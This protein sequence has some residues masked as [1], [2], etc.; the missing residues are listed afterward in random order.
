MDLDAR[1]IKQAVLR[2][3]FV[4]SAGSKHDL[5]RLTYHRRLTTSSFA[6]SRNG[7]PL[8]DGLIS[9]VARE[10]G[11][12]KKLFVDFV[13]GLV[14]D[15]D[16][17]DGISAVQEIHAEEEELAKRQAAADAQRTEPKETAPV[18]RGP[19]EPKR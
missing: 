11:V 2:V 15:Q 12:K 19:G 16:F 18:A 17:L 13:R 10:I 8:R 5:Y 6:M 3:G 14:A 1:A 7:E 9:Q 4:H